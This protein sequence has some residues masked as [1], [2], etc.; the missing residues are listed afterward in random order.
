MESKVF[1]RE[2]LYNLVSRSLKEI[3]EEYLVS[4]HSFK[5]IC[6]SHQI[7]LPPQ[8]HWSKKRFGKESPPILLPNSDKSDSISLY[9]RK[10]GNKRDLGTLSY[11]VKRK[12]EIEND[13]KVNL[14]VPKKL[15]RKLDPIVSAT[16]SFLP[17]DHP[18]ENGIWDFTKR[19]SYGKIS[20]SASEK[21]FSRSLRIIHTLV[22]AIKA[23]GHTFSFIYHRSY[24]VING[25]ELV[26]RFREKQK[27]IQIIEESGWK[28][29]KLE[30]LG[31]ITLITGEYSARKE[32]NESEN[33]PIERKLSQIITYLEI[34]AEEKFRLKTINDKI[35][36]ERRVQ[37]KLEQERAEIREAEVNKLKD[38]I[39]QS[40]QWYEAQKLRE[41]LNYLSKV[42]SMKSESQP[43]IEDLIQFGLD[44]ADWLDP[45]LNKKDDIL[46][47]V[48]PND[49]F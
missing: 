25:I 21:I 47:G 12:L 1:T 46:E 41:Y 49:F 32:W 18:K 15:P 43:E 45:T 35:L 31:L 5:K 22:E 42:S 30:P 23:R 26:L 27:R 3:T 16:K 38:L 33:L 9:K 48:N 7:P 2:E 34:A 11:F 19:Y 44:K 14:E 36:K 10:E 8:G 39:A 4:Y 29:S 6:K 40:R 28:S 13:P 20:V 37:E 17:V 24:I